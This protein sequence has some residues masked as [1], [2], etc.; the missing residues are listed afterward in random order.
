MRTGIERVAASPTIELADFSGVLLHTLFTGYLYH[1]RLDSLF[2]CL[3]LS[4]RLKESKGLGIQ[5]EKDFHHLLHV[6]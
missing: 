2:V 4:F 1:R 5:V 3:F 6:T